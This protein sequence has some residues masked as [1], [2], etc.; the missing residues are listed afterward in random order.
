MEDPYI[1][2]LGDQFDDSV[3]NEIDHDIKFLEELENVETRD[4]LKGSRSVNYIVFMLNVNN[5]LIFIEIGLRRDTR[6]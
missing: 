5:I 1:Y 3:W 2:N 4:I 6:T